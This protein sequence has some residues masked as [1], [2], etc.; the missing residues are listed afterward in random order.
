M[1]NWLFFYE[2]NNYHDA[3]LLYTTLSKVSKSFGIKISK[4]EWIEMSDNSPPK[5]WTD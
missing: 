1:S 2:K 4:P 3:E 5:D